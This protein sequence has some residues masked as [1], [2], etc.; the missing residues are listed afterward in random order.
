MLVD[1]SNIT[2]V[3]PTRV[4]AEMAAPPSTD[5]IIPRS[6]IHPKT[7]NSSIKVLIKILSQSMGR[8]LSTIPVPATFFSEPISFLQRA[9]EILEY[10]FLLDKAAEC[11]DPL[12]Q[13]LYIAGFNVSMYSTFPERICKAFNPLLSE[14]F[15]LSREK[16]YGWKSL[17]EQVS[18][19]PPRLVQVIISN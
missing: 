6:S 5:A 16:E 9:A 1:D 10:S 14:T 3:E 15:E 4:A 12:E 8:D 7:T 18:H 11:Q 17:C 19:H 13:M 2:S